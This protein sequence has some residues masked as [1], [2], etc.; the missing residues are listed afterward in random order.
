[1]KEQQEQQGKRIIGLISQVSELDRTKPIKLNGTIFDVDDLRKG[2]ATASRERHLS[3]TLGGWT[4]GN[5]NAIETSS[6][7]DAKRSD[8]NAKPTE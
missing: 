4:G 3:G 6:G 5:D 2:L 7:K 8:E 1:M